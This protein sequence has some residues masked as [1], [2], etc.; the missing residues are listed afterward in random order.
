[1]VPFGFIE[2]SPPF[3]PGSRG[4]FPQSGFLSD[5]PGQMGGECDLERQSRKP[6]ERG[7]PRF[8]RGGTLNMEDRAMG[9]TRI[10][11][12]IVII[13]LA[14]ILL[15]P[16]PDATVKAGAERR[17]RAARAGGRAAVDLDRPPRRRRGEPGGWRTSI[18][19]ATAPTGRWRRPPPRSVFTTAT[20]G[21]TTSGPSPTPIGS[22]ASRRS[23]R[24]SCALALCDRT[25]QPPGSRPAT[26]RFAAASRCWR[27][28]CGR[29]RTST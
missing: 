2:V 6:A 21:F 3:R 10:L 22:R 26:T 11:D 27:R 1:M 29:S 13:L 24:P 16:R 5:P 19:T 23:R 8:R 7:S 12:L 28:R 18:S 14:T 9:I 17:R 25:P 15:M 4:F 20:I